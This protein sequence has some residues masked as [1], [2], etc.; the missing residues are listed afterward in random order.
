MAQNACFDEAKRFLCVWLTLKKDW[1]CG[2]PKTQHFRL[3]RRTARTEQPIFIAKGSKCVF[4]LRRCP[5]W[6]WLTSE[7][8]WGRGGPKT[9]TFSPDNAQGSAFCGSAW[10]LKKMG[11]W[12]TNNSKIFALQC[13]QPQRYWLKMRVLTKRSAFYASDWL[14]KKTGDVGAQKPQNLSLAMRSVRTEQPIFMVS[15]LKCVSWHKEGPFGGSDWLFRKLGAWGP[16]SPKFS[17]YNATRK[18]CEI[19]EKLLLNIYRKMVSIFQNPP[20]WILYDA[21]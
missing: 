11:V 16:K 3:T 8:I 17:P 15:G 18:W 2:G 13:A 7:Q 1:G 6:V 14:L 9:S 21:Y 4:W 20:S 19:E 5:M 12:G 10:P